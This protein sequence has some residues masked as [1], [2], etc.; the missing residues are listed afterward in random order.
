MFLFRRSK[1]TKTKS[2]VSIEKKVKD[3]GDNI[4]G[5]WIGFIFM[6]W[7]QRVGKLWLL[8][9]CLIIVM[10]LISMLVIKYSIIR[11]FGII[12]S[13]YLILLSFSWGGFF[14][15]QIL[16]PTL[17]FAFVLFSSS[18][19]YW[20]TIFDTIHAEVAWAIQQNSKL[21]EFIIN[22][23]KYLIVE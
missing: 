3:L 1:K 18:V 20:F 11:V 19:N 8:Y 6:D 23:I 9:Y 22:K 21:S 12:L 16:N 15:G 2:L 7:K 14:P 13:Y 4:I 17:I 5:H 10:G